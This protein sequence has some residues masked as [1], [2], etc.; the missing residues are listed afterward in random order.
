[1]ENL[2]LQNLG[3]RIKIFRQN[4][5]LSQES[6]AQQCGF[7]RTYISLLERG[8][9]NPSYLNLLKLCQGLEIKITELL[10]EE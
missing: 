7:D 10:M 8:K 6:L 5:S 1:M 2:I 4:L 9:R 3:N